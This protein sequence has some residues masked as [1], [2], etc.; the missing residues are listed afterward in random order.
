VLPSQERLTRAGLFKRAYTA[1]KTVAT[2]I[3]TLYVLP[4]L[5]RGRTQVRTKSLV[6]TRKTTLANSCNSREL[7][8]IQVAALPLVGFVVA[9]KVC[10]SACVRNKAKRRVREAY[11][12]MR[13]SS[14]E[15]RDKLALW[16]AM[17]FVVHSKVL[18]AQWDEI[19][20]AVKECLERA[21][22][23]YGQREY[24]GG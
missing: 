9:K 17:V 4:R 23:K 15:L 13:L 3:V 6:E 12:L 18:D 7:A 10:K 2:P 20:T 16:Y 22:S 1:R 21:H 11:R 19:Q 24:K 8:R 14:K 5:E